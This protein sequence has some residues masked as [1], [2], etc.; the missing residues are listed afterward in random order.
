MVAPMRLASIIAVCVL[1]L[2][3]MG[4]KQASK[5]VS[6]AESNS[7]S[8]APASELDLAAKKRQNMVV[9]LM[10]LKPKEVIERCGKPDRDFT[11]QVQ[12]F[13]VGDSM[14]ERALLYSSGLKGY[15]VGLYFVPDSD[16][17]DKPNSF[18]G[19]RTFINGEIMDD[20]N[21]SKSGK[22]TDS[23]LTNLAGALPCLEIQ[24][25]QSD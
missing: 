13:G 15:R 5:T 19:A 1:A 10:D 16:H 2:A 25:V 4:C 23:I 24:K 9:N 14:P 12:V 11:K 17:L 20:Y 22:D 8:N 21:I 7:A 6:A 3:P 18:F